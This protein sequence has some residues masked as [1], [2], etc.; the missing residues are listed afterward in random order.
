[1]MMALRREPRKE[2][3]GVRSTEGTEYERVREKGGRGPEPSTLLSY[4][5]G[6]VSENISSLSS[7]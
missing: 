7:N 2:N 3:G 1:M 4:R 6:R 5:L